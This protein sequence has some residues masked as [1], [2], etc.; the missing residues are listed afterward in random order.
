MP[1]IRHGTD[2][3]LRS[4]PHG[5]GDHRIATGLFSRE[6][7]DERHKRHLSLD[8]WLVI[9]HY[10]ASGLRMKILQRGISNFKH[11]GGRNFTLDF[12]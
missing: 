1:E 7:D 6:W 12:R 8:H 5:T 2:L 11:A 3:S 9:P 10:A 4:S